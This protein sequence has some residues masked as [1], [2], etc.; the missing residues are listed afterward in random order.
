M[1]RRMLIAASALAVLVLAAVLLVISGDDRTPVPDEA[2]ETVTEKPEFPRTLAELGKREPRSRQLDFERWETD[3]G[4]RVLFMRAP[5]LPMVES[6]LI[7]NAGAAR[8]G[9]HPG[10]AALVNHLLDQGADGL[11]VDE[12]ASGFEDLGARLSTSSHR[13]MAVV[14]LAVLSD[15]QYRIPAFEL[16]GR[17]LAHP[18]FPEDALERARNRFLQSLRMKRERPGP[19]VDRAFYETLFGEHPYGIPP[20]GTEESIA[21]I[22]R[23][24]LVDFHRRYY[25][26]A[27]AVIA[28][29]GDLEREDAERVAA[30]ISATLPEGEPA[31]ALPDFD[32]LEERKVQ[33]IDF[34]TFQTH[35]HIGNSLIPRGHP[36]YAALHVGNHILG[37]GGFTS[38]LMEEVRQ[39]RGLVYGVRSSVTPMAAA[40]PF[41]ITLQ[42][43]N[44]NA[45]EALG[46]TLA[47]VEDLVRDGPTDE[48]ME[49]ALD[50]LTGSFPLSTESNRQLV[51]QLGSIGFYDLPLD[52]LERFQEEVRTMTAEKV[53]NAMR[54]HLHP[55]H[56]SI[57]SIGPEAPAIPERSELEEIREEHE[58]TDPVEEVPAPERA[59][60]PP[61]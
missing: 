38:M 9:D 37:G 57:V 8:D 5:Q 16:L 48:Q 43:A 50:Y 21:E 12:I 20:D 47:L 33:H 3:E 61:Q 36:D 44:E 19:Q 10:Q 32:T 45:D 31:D 15:E 56:L 22:S 30:R 7:F 59:H 17:V 52:H 29:A 41:R 58:E 26:A 2:R 1:S 42:T 11:D 51:G 25:A 54:R 13:D 24:Q 28:L 4:A 14:D 53:R 49:A 6:R 55:D 39:R 18:E 34:D 27:N 35:I 46:L 40:G 23:E 60:E